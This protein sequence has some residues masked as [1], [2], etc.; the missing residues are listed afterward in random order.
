MFQLAK[1]SFKLIYAST[2]ALGIWMSAVSY[3]LGERL[4]EMLLKVFE[5]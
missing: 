1:L 5:F 4:L 2:A 3:W